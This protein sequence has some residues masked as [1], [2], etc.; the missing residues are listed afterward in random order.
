MSAGQFAI[1][2]V[3]NS[4]Y[5]SSTIAGPRTEAQ[6]DDYLPALTYGMSAED[7]A[8][9]DSLVSSGHPSTPGFNDPKHP[10]FGRIPRRESQGE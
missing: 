1:A 4:R 10:F 7:E 5:I 8:F 6:W 9:V 2:W 3:L